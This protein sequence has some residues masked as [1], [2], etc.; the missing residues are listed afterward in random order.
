MQPPKVP[1][2]PVS[3]EGRKKNRFRDVLSDRI[4]L[5]VIQVGMNGESLPVVR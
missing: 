5:G 3:L 2:T 1:H 4:D